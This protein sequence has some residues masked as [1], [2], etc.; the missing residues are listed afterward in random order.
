MENL[1]AIGNEQKVVRGYVQRGGGASAFGVTAGAA[2]ADLRAQQV[3]MLSIHG[4][5]TVFSMKKSKFA[6]QRISFILWQGDDGV[7]ASASKSF[8][9]TIHTSRQWRTVSVSLEGSRKVSRTTLG[10]CGRAIIDQFLKSAD[11]SRVL[12]RFFD[13]LDQKRD[14]SILFDSGRQS[15]SP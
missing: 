8:S 7:S 2:V 13:W 12:K 6:D 15:S 9:L 1:P 5:Q 3:A 14:R 11:F 10:R 4:L